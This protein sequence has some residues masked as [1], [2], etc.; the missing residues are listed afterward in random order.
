[1]ND[2]PEVCGCITSEIKHTVIHRV[3]R[4]KMFLMSSG[5]VRVLP[6]EPFSKDYVSFFL[7]FELI[8]EN[9]SVICFDIQA[10]VS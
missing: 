8:C 3:T 4:S 10:V 5:D 7:L 1:M 2:V 9:I 6:A